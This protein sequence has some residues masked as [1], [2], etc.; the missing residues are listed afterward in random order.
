MGKINSYK[1]LVGK[2]EVKRLLG[3]YRRKWKGNIKMDFRQ[4]RWGSYG[5]NSSGS[6][7]GPVVAVIL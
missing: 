5:Q 2:L 6:G 7:E 4:I 1:I 3:R